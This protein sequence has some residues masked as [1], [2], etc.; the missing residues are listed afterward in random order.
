M[1]VFGLVDEAGPPRTI[2]DR[3]LKSQGGILSTWSGPGGQQPQGSC[4]NSAV[5][6]LALF[7]TAIPTLMALHPG[8]PLY[9]PC[10]HRHCVPTLGS[11]TG[12][13]AR[14]TAQEQRHQV[15]SAALRN[16]KRKQ[17]ARSKSKH[18]P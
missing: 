15:P 10:N 1:W 5:R 6:P 16:R 17:K 12:R 18:F 9:S 11:K 2:N 14:G 13:R 7:H 3:V 4:L 8:V